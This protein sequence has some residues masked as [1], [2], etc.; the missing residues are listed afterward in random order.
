MKPNNK[1]FNA[2]IETDDGS[3][4]PIHVPDEYFDEYGNVRQN[5]YLNYLTVEILKILPLNTS[6]QKI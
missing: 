2:Y 3:L 6:N 1:R 5:E 4:L